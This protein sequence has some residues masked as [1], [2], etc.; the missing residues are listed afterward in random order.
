M[1]A[2]RYPDDFEGIVAGAPC[3]QLEHGDGCHYDTD[4]TQC[5]VP[6]SR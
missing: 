5:D 6:R 4:C 3:I 2:Q 1:E